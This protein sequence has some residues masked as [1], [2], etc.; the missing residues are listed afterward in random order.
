MKGLNSLGKR[1]EL[2]SQPFIYIFM[3]V[4]I[5]FIV[6]FGFT[7]LQKLMGFGCT[8]ETT[9]LTHDF[10]LHVKQMYSFSAGS[11]QKYSLITPS[12]LVGICFVDNTQSPNLLVIP[13]QSV[14][15]YIEAMSEAGALNQ[16]VFFSGKD[17]DCTPSPYRIEN[18]IVKGGTLCFHVANGKFDYVLENKGD[19]VEIS[20]P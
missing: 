2:L 5:G 16:N 10:D 11:N 17:V 15:E 8:I 18:L 1:G 9:K 4:V 3:I 6:V 19:F 14:K 20:K 12:D 13:Y 7:G